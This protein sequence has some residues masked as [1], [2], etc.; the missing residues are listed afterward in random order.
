MQKN[1]TKRVEVVL[2]QLKKD[3]PSVYTP[4]NH[5]SAYQITIAL[6]LSPQTPDA[7]TNKV[8]PKLFEKY[9]TV[10]TLSTAH[11]SDV[12]KLISPI[13]YNKTKAKRIILAAQQIC[14]D[15]AGEIP[16]DIDKLLTLPGVG[17]KVA[18]A[19]IS[20]WFV[21]QNKNIEPVGFVV[22]THVAR[23]AKRL[24]FTTHTNPAKIEIDLMN[25]IPKKEWPDTSL[26]FIFHGREVSA[27]KN[28]IF[29]EHPV[30]K[31]IY[32]EFGN[33]AFW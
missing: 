12:L 8:T 22:D 1:K 21:R 27:A 7:T 28:P 25:Q 18:N 10:Q 20:E 11:E 15:F 3:Y 19:I 33:P 9:P 24:G 14:T 4:L 31:P 13:N 30:W 17:R 32:L 6:M 26:R 23:I 16:S 29:L 5:I 2:S